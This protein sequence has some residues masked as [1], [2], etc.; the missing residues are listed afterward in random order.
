MTPRALA[1]RRLVLF[2]MLTTLGYHYPPGRVP[3]VVAGIR[4][5]LGGWPGWA[6]S[7]PAWQQYDVRLP[8]YGGHGWATTFY[9]QGIGDGRPRL[10]ARAVGSGAAGR[11]GGVAAAGGGC[12]V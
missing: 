8:R 5:Y 10:S 9:P 12:L 2:T 4:Q 3:P 1:Q 6:A 7:S 11:M